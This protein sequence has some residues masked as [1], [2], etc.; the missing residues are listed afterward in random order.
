[1]S[2]NSKGQNS[3]LQNSQLQNI[4][5]VRSPDDQGKVL[6]TRR[7]VLGAAL[8]GLPAMGAVGFAAHTGRIDLLTPTL[9]AHDAVLPAVSGVTLLGQPTPGI[10]RASFSE[11]VTLLHVWASW[12][13]TCRKEHALYQKLGERTDIQVFG[14]GNDDTA[15]KMAEYL[16][17]VGNPYKRLSVD[18]DRVYIRTLKQRGVPSTFVI[19]KNGTVAHRI[20][21][22]LST[23][24]INTEI[25]QAINKAKAM[26]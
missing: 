14:L 18:M 12:C 19:A 15:D 13:P 4:H 7:M 22:A 3:Q 25:A 8:L 20:H 1:M 21:D 9:P 23:T 10:S 5:V 6:T 26:A 11:A 2:E 24:L 16:G 17:K